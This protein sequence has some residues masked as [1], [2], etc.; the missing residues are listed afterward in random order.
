[1][2]DPIATLRWLFPR[3]SDK[4]LWRLHL[5][6]SALPLGW[7]L[8][9]CLYAADVRLAIGHWPRPMVEAGPQDV[10]SSFLEFATGILLLPVTYSFLGW[11]VFT[12]WRWKK[13]T[14]R[15]RLW[16]VC[17]YIAGIVAAA[18]FSWANPGKFVDWWMD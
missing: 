14:N 1:M 3:P 7:T 17:L 18:V 16:Q 15:Q 10:F 8:L 4:V 9:M 11:I 6:V 5:A 13:Y 2:T 12:I